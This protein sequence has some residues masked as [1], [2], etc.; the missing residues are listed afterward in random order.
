[1]SENHVRRGLH[2]LEGKKLLIAPQLGYVSKEFAGELTRRVEN[3]ATLVVLDPDALTGDIESGSLQAER[4]RLLGLGEC[5]KRSAAEMRPAKA[6]SSRFKGVK[7]LALRPLR[8]VGDTN[9]ARTIAIPSGARVLFTYPDGAP[10]AYSRKLG[11]GEVIVFGAMPF[12][13][14]ELAVNPSGWDTL[15]GTLID[16]LKIR[17]DLP[18][19]RFLF[20]ATGDEPKIFEPALKG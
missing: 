14:S 6:A 8:I 7:T 15:F 4:Q 18:V 2:S 19:W 20:P 13:D 5:A 11:K 12:R 10:A 9:N 16:E 1:V 17:R 3:G